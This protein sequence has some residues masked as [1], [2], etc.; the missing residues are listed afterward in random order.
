M[1]FSILCRPIKALKLELIP[2]PYEAFTATRT[3]HVCAIDIWLCP[4]PY[5]R[6]FPAALPL[7]LNHL[8]GLN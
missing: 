6:P 8:S 2:I 7:A 5:L 4:S 1:R 3:I